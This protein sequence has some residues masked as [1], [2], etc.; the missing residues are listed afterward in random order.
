MTSMMTVHRPYR[1]AKGERGPAC[2]WVVDGFL[3]G[4]KSFISVWGWGVGVEALVDENN[5]QSIN[6]NFS[7]TS[8]MLDGGGI[9]ISWDGRDREREGGRERRGVEETERR[10]VEETGR[11]GEWKRQR[12]TGSGR[13]RV[14]GREAKWKRGGVE[15]REGVCGIDRGGRKKGEWKR[16]GKRW[17][18]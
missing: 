11:D 17:G 13:D 15:E 10:G 4:S 5:G 16:E 18:S 2:P 1:Q 6:H 9:E 14:R 7:Y 12:E 8:W 3:R